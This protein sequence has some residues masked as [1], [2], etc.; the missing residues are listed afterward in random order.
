MASEQKDTRNTSSGVQCAE[1]VGSIALAA[2]LRLG[3]PLDHVL[4]ACVV[5]TRF[6]CLHHRPRRIRKP[7][8]AT[9]SRRPFG[10]RLASAEKEGGRPRRWDRGSYVAASPRLTAQAADGS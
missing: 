7:S 9:L 5:A 4:R 10:G 1:V 2:D 8:L 3:Q 6:A